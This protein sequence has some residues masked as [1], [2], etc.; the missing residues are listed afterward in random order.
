MPSTSNMTLD[1]AFALA[2]DALVNQGFSLDQAGAI[3][4]TVTAAERDGC[5]SHGLFR[6]PFYVKA[7]QNPSCRPDAEPQVSVGA[8]AVINVDAG[9]GFCPLALKRGLEP[10]IERTRTHGIGALAIHKVYN[11]AA[12]W[13]EVEHLAEEGLVAMAF[14][15]ATSTVAP[16]GGIRPLFGT[17]PMAF[18]WPRHGHPPL[19]FD[20]ASSA[21]ARGEIQ[22]RLRDGETLPDGW[23]IDKDGQPTNDPAAA[24]A[25]AQLPFGGHKGSSLALMVELLA[26]ALLGDL[27][28]FEAT[29]ADTHKTGSPFGG[30]LV[31]A[32]DPSHFAP[33]KT[34]P[35]GSIEAQ[36][37]HAEQLFERILAQEGTRLPSDR[38][39]RAR[40]ETASQ[41]IEVDSEL[42]RTVR[43]YR[44]NPTQRSAR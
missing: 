40:Q 34:T 10:L 8:S 14:T 6:I 23:A 15:A 24:L 36:T 18:A 43:D 22:L 31:L 16:A 11:I 37:R 44:D 26:G 1:D 41:G 5:Q 30:E 3:S 29:E 35:G 12:L 19:V 4:E 42:L 33:E 21:S 20:Q 32:I 38:R 7:L 17:N 2:R 27:F 9:N 39:Y 13:P 25:G 28:S